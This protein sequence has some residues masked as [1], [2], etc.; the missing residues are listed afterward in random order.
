[1]LFYTSNGF[2]RHFFHYLFFI[3]VYK[4]YLGINKYVPTIKCNLEHS[5]KL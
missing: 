4:F 1:M 2:N 3:F 5:H